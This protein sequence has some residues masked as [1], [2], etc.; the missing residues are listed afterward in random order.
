[1]CKCGDVRNMKSANYLHLQMEKFGL[2]VGFITLPNIFFVCVQ[3]PV[4]DRK[5]VMWTNLIFLMKKAGLY[6]LYD[7]L[8]FDCNF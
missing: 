7:L 1:M 6:F 2:C 3:G 4:Y 8:L 5:N